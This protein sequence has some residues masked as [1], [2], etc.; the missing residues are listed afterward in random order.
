VKHTDIH[1]HGEIHRQTGLIHELCIN[2]SLSNL[3]K[4]DLPCFIGH[5]SEATD[6]APVDH[7]LMDIEGQT[8]KKPVS[9][10][11]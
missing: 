9:A 2:V 7:N 11:M 1:R 8:R 6:L 3:S 4:S 5:Y 10:H